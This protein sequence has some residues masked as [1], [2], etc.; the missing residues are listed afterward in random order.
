MLKQLA[1]VLALAAFGCGGGAKSATMPTG[2]G[3]GAT[4]VSECAVMAAHVAEQVMTWKEP[5]PTTKE[6]VANVVSAQCET[7][8]WTAEAKKCFGGIT[9]EESTK[10]CIATLTKQQHDNVMNAMESKFEKKHDDPTHDDDD[11]TA[12]GGTGARKPAPASAPPPPPASKG[13]AK[14]ADPCEGGE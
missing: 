7:D 11:S 12:D 2:G 6:N 5:P 3:G 9:D 14:G 13:P 10:P 1:V 4:P 8:Q